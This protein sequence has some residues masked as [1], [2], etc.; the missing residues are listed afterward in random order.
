ML[1]IGALS[2][3]FLCFYISPDYIFVRIKQTE[4]ISD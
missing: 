3:S 1:R 2:Q 4:G